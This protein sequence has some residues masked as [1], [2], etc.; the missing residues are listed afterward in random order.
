[1]AKARRK[2]G[3]A[4]NPDLPKAL[5]AAVTR[6]ETGLLPTA[7]ADDEKE[8][9]NLLEMLCPR[10][11]KD[12]RHKG[13]GDPPNVLMEPLLMISWDRLN[14]RFKW[15]ITNRIL[16][17]TGGLGLTQ[18]SGLAAEIERQLASGEVPWKAI[19]AT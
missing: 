9:P 16:N 17:T 15:V 1:M 13:S 18:L 10:V 7:T 12:P 3:L 19:K 11:V 8:C 14:G 5:A 4:V 6:A 2:D